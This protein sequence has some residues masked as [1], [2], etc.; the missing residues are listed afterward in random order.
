MRR[1]EHFQQLPVH[2]AAD[3]S[4][5]HGQGQGQGMEEGQFTEG[6]VNHRRQMSPGQYK[7]LAT[8]N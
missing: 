7:K 4:A 5:G 6:S 3:C 8:G 2:Q 1:C